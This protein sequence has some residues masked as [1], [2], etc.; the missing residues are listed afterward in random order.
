MSSFAVYVTDLHCFIK[1]TE[2]ILG[3]P[4]MCTHTGGKLGPGSPF[5]RGNGGPGV[6][7]FQ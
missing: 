4:Q 7:I 6:P 5:S 3:G 1:N 2:M